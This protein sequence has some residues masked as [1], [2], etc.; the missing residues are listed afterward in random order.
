MHTPSFLALLVV[1]TLLLPAPARAAHPNELKPRLRTTDA[2][3]QELLTFGLEMSP[4]MRALVAS[5]NASDVVVYLRCAR[6]PPRIDGQLTFVSSGGGLRYVVVRIAWDRSQMRRLSIL[7]HEL[8][9][10]LE[11]AARPDI[12]DQESLALAY[13]GFGFKR[14]SLGHRSAAFDTDAAIHAGDRV[15]REVNG[16]VSADD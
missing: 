11:I 5:L 2:Q 14:E 7:G 8:Q 13:A 16:T 15:W 3:M 12:V 4:S 9:H 10:A 1:A 6:L